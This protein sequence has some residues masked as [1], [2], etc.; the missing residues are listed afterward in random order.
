MAVPTLKLTAC[1][2]SAAYVSAGLRE[3]NPRAAVF[4]GGGCRG[5]AMG[6]FCHEHT[7]IEVIYAAATLNY[8]LADYLGRFEERW[9]VMCCHTPKSINRI[10]SSSARHHP[11]AMK[12]GAE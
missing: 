1:H 6:S 2:E 4:A 10:P 12:K 5:A 9:C 3:V 11:Q 7:S 8:T